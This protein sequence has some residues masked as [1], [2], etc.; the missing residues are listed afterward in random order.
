VF[1]CGGARSGNNGLKYQTYFCMVALVA[2]VMDKKMFLCLVAL[3]ATAM[4]LDETQTLHE[5]LT[6]RNTTDCFHGSSTCN[7]LLHF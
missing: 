5:Q 3:S 6:L 2:E 7:Q 4:D 1:L